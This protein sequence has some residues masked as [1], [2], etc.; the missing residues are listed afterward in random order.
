MSVHT[1]Y[2]T[3]LRLFKGR[4]DYFAEQRRD[5]YFPIHESL[6]EFYVARHLS[7]D[8]TF[9]IYLLT[10]SS[11]CHLVCIDVDIPKTE[12]NDIDFRDCG[13]NL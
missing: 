12:L 6:D 7:G 2:G 4:E 3:Y 1:N 11:C 13:H 8:T 5:R 9:G 10:N